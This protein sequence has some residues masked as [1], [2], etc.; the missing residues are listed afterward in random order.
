MV[1]NSLEHFR[2][3][4]VVSHKR[5]F[6]NAAAGNLTALERYLAKDGNIDG[7]DKD[8]LALIHYAACHGN[9]PLIR[10]LYEHGA[11]MNLHDGGTPAWKP[12]H[13]AILHRKQEAE[14]I[15]R[16]FGA[17]VPLPILK[18]IALEKPR[19]RQNEKDSWVFA[20]RM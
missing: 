9:I 16:T 8:G 2:T 13:Y 3:N 17:Q 10:K 20:S 1:T 19:S 6:V 15:L 11:D 18:R 5:L 7:R 12:I 14:E 4:D